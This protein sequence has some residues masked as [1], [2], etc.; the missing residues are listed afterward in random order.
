MVRLVLFGRTM[1][2][3]LANGTMRFIQARGAIRIVISGGTTMLFQTR[4]TKELVL[5]VVKNNNKFGPS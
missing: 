3:I 4:S 2:L 5:I 1:K